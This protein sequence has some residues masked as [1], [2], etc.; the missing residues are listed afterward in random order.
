QQ[1]VVPWRDQS[2]HA[3]GLVDDLADRVGPFGVDGAVC[4]GGRQRCVVSQDGGGVVDVY[5]A[6]CQ[7]LARVE[8]LQPR[9]FFPLRLERIGGGGEDACAT[10]RWGVGLGVFVEGG[11][12]GAYR[13]VGVGFGGFGDRRQRRG[14]VGIDDRSLSV[15]LGR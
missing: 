5:L 3:H 12:G 7:G 8:R 9:Q 6:L 14:V 11:S 10:G 1:W 15:V 4:V 13:P 2:A